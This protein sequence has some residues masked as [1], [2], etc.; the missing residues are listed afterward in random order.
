MK[1][2]RWVLTF[3]I[4]LTFAGAA[5]AQDD[6][7]WK[8]TYLA[9]LEFARQ[10]I[11]ENHP[12]PVD[13][14]NAAFRRTF[15]LAYGEAQ[16]A[17]GQVKSST[18]Y[19]LALRRFANR[20]QDPNL[21]IEGTRP[22]ERMKSAGIYP[23]WRG[24]AFVVEEVAPRYGEQVATL[25]GSTIV[26]CDGIPAA[27]QFSNGVLSWHGRTA[28]QGDWA[29]WAPLLLVD[30]GPPMMKAPAQCNFRNAKGTETVE[31]RWKP[32]TA[33]EVEMVQKRIVEMPARAPRLSKLAD[34]TVWVDV[35]SFPANGDGDAVAM[36][37]M[38]DSLAAEVKQ[39]PGWKLI[40]FDLRGSG[41]GSLQWGEPL[42]A[43]VFGKE[44][45]GA[46]QAWL[47]D[48][49]HAEWRVSK[50]NLEAQPRLAEPMRAAMAKSRALLDQPS[51]AKGAK[52]PAAPAPAGKKVVI[53]TSPSCHGACLDFLD[54]LKISPA[55]VQ[56]GQ[57]TGADTVYAE[58]STLALPSGLGS[59]RF[60]MQ[61]VRDR[62]RKNNEAYAPKV[63]YSGK[64][65][66]TD[67]LQKWI[68]AGY[69]S[70]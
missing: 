39:N 2:V 3:L 69:R 9:D 46:A 21:V 7:D 33:P 12:G 37:G 68:T 50:H 49:V 70:W 59:I 54:L 1:S 64:L 62:K 30:Y 56:V 18:A 14:G 45:A 42:A 29:L 55:V 24:S 48:G 58:T 63:V 52:R 40:V 61:V 36:R 41:G 27:H 16:R 47:N 4:P 60:P 51:P 22:F 20:L 53:V 25:K 32:T 23:A 44:W 6:T 13:D 5:F 26:S 66:D 17:A 57:P 35:P 28:V 11:A 31:L 15:D 10:V 8:A 65:A 67:A 19:T 38:I 43:A 34:G